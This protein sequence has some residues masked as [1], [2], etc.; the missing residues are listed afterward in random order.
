[1]RGWHFRAAALRSGRAPKRR[2]DVNCAKRRG[3]NSPALQRCTASSSTPTH[4]VAI[5]LW[6]T[7]CAPSLLWSPS[8]QMWR[9][10]GQ[11]SFCWPNFRLTRPPPRARGSARSSQAR[12]R[13][14]RGALAAGLLGADDDSL[15][16]DRARSIEHIDDIRIVP[17]PPAA[18]AAPRPTLGSSHAPPATG[19]ARSRRSPPR[20]RTSLVPSA[21]SHSA[22]RG[23]R[24]QN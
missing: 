6:S 18:W 9:S 14:Q 12:G 13:R 20:S 15:L 22:R 3:S 11:P 10:R 19:A 8:N 5:T 21:S 17:T 23:C 4:P 7:S 1:M 2:C 16:R 24:F